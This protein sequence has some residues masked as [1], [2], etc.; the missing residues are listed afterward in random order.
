M[1]LLATITRKGLETKRHGFAQTA[2]GVPGGVSTTD[3]PT[4]R[5]FASLLWRLADLTQ[6]DERRRSFRAKAYRQAI[7]SLDELAPDLDQPAVTMLAVP[8]IG[9]GLVGLIEEF[10]TTGSLARL[11]T[12]QARYPREVARMRRLPRANPGV[13]RAM[14]EELGVETVG[15]L[16]VAIDTGG[17]MTLPGVGEATASLWDRVIAASRTGGA[18]AHRAW[19]L[20]R[21]LAEH[22]E[23]HLEVLVSETG[24]VRRVEEWVD[25]VE[26]VVGSD[27]GGQIRD[28]LA[29]TAVA[30][31]SD[32]RDMERI[33]LETHDDMRAVV[34]VA[35][36]EGFG[37]A[38]VET[39]G[40]ESHLHEVFPDGV[41]P[42]FATE[43]EVYDAVGLDWMPP[44][45]RVRPVDEAITAVT[46]AD[47]KGDLHL[48]T[49]DSPDGR[50]GL[51]QL[52]KACV[53]RG[54]RYL[55]VTDHTKGLRFGG[56]D[57]EGIREQSRL[58][59]EVRRQIPGI[60]IFHGA[61]LNIGMEG[62]L[63]IADDAL[64][65][66]D[67][68]VAAVH[69]WFGL[70]E[71]RQTKRVITAMRHP[72]VKVLAHPQGRRIGIRLP[73][74]LDLP[75]VFDS[76]AEEGV[77]LE[78]NGHRDRLDLSAELARRAVDS[79]CVLAANSDAHRFGELANI[80]NA[81]ATAQRA[82]AH[83]SQVINTW[84]PDELRVWVPGNQ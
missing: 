42:S 65:L 50:I 46:V 1:S 84:E 81:V 31:E 49:E 34:H 12:L 56:L 76:A 40:P 29:T 3:Q 9:P 63:D 35:G 33:V 72:K 53:A 24:T 44:A 79:G 23:S 27:E 32:T 36:P 75:A 71:G 83:P 22:L 45:A 60:E 14:K 48:H 55:L 4:R 51:E 41:I 37:S 47:L 67:F 58:V 62:E 17:V 7:W 61:E 39:T 69:S 68:A 15:D 19:V 57:E 30:S 74:D 82:G 52:V 18:P 59:H 26:L 28:F 25:A 66:L 38:L 21:Q 43:P 5:R 54:Y 64:E 8:G 16:R 10:T 77:A 11:D 73:L 2:R 13:L 70:D 80:E 6:V 78:L 20:A